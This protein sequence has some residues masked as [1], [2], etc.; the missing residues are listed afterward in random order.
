MQKIK[1]FT[2]LCLKVPKY[3]KVPK[4][5]NKYQKIYLKVSKNTSKHQK[6]LTHPKVHVSLESIY[7][8]KKYL[9]ADYCL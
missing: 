4:N 7:K 6:I 1:Y 9:Y 5:T 3:L 8:H 2:P